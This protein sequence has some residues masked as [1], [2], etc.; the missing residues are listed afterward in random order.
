MSARQAAPLAPDLEQGLKRLKL[1]RM[2]QLAPELLQTAK[3]QRW[4]PEE[5]LRTLVEAEIAARDEANLRGRLRVAGFPQP[6]RLD[7]FQLAA[8]SI[9][10]A[11]FDYLAGLEWVR[12]ADNACLIG[13][14]GTGKS[15]VLIGCGL[16]AVEAGLRVRYLRADELVEHLYR[17]LADNSV[18][19]QID[20]LLRFDLVIVDEIGFAPLDDTGAQLLFRFVAAAYERRSLGI[21]SHWPFEEW[22]RFLPEHATAV[23]LLDRLLHHATVVVTTGESFRMKEAKTRG[24]GRPTSR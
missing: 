11:T 17:G 21:A 7:D 22:G 23:A 24:G 10:R 14:P 20:Q 8:S 6:K 13:P 2:R 9:P 19:K 15:H 1:R 16:A 18:G 3:T 5:L 12:S 4:V